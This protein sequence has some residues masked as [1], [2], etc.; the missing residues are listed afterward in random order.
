MS[1]QDVVAVYI[2]ITIICIVK[3]IVVGVYLE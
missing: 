3:S 1:E 2:C